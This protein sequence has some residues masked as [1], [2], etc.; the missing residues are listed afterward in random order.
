MKGFGSKAPLV[1]RGPRLLRRFALAASLAALS[2]TASSSPAGAASVT[3]GQLAAVPAPPCTIAPVERAQPTVTSGNSYVVPATGGVTSW[4]LTSWSHAA[5]TSTGQTLTMKV[6][7]KVAD[8]ATFQVV[9]H[10]GPRPL[11]GGTLNT[12]QASVPVRSGDVLGFYQPTATPTACRLTAP[13][14]TFQFLHP[15]TL[16]DGVSAPFSTSATDNRLNISAV[17]TPTNTFSVGA[18]TRNKKKGTATVTATVPNPGELNGSGKGVKVASA[19][20]A[21]TSKSVT[22]GKVK[23]TITAKGKK[24]KTLNETGKVKVKPTLTYTP[25]GGDPS[26]QSTKVKLKKNL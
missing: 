13:G 15:G 6:Y 18:I 22:P 26:T 8:P 17:V 25:T 21:V 20:G 19:A 24:Q 14:D 3:I 10:D 9:G 12:F 23:L 11:V 2:L 16:N 7:R 1:R 4:V 5:G